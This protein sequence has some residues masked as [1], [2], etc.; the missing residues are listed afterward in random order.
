MAPMNMGGVTT[1]GSRLRIPGNN[2]EKPWTPAAATL[3]GGLGIVSSM[4]EIE[5]VPVGELTFRV[6]VT[7]GGAS[8]SHEVTVSP[9]ETALIGDRDPADLVE[10]SI[11]FLLEREPK[12]SILRRFDLSMIA[13]YFPEYPTK[14]GEYL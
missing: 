7:E 8:T 12:E 1:L 10:A 5:V 3:L 14:I 9:D 6:T 13:R 4:A 11:R 2:R